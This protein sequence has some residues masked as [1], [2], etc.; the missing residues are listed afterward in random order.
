MS[1][2]YIPVAQQ[3]VDQ[4]ETHSVMDVLKSGKFAA[5]PKCTEFERK[6][7]AFVGRKALLCNSGSSA[8]LLAISTLSAKTMPEMGYDRLKKG[9]EVITP[10]CTFPTTVNPLFQNGFVPVFVDVDIRTLNVSLEQIQ[11]G[12]STKTKAIVVP[13]TLGNVCEIDKISEWCKKENLYLIEDACDAMGA[14]MNGQK[15]GT[16]GDMATSSFFPAHHVSCGEGGA[17]FVSTN[18]LA[19]VVESLRDWG[20]A[21][22]C[23]PGCDNTCKKRFDYQLGSLPSGYDHKYSYSN[24][25]YNLK[26]SDLQAAI[27]CAQMGKLEGFIQKRRDNWSSLYCGINQSSILSEHLIAIEPTPGSTPSWFGFAMHLDPKL[28][29]RDLMKH[30]EAHQVGTRMVFGGNITRQ[31]GYEDENFKVIR[32]L[33]NCDR[34][35]NHTFWIAVH[36]GLTEDNIDFMLQTL[37]DGIN[38]QL[39]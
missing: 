12:F 4:A 31:P 18:R 8:N 6:L 28:S 29:R 30:M 32:E 2:P 13:H 39:K 22:W 38:A 15:V 11:S 3:I 16:F 36:P 20:R 34:I 17:V 19:R 35:M 33:Q 10:A 23:N 7:E 14:E 9:D 27:G 5:G 1:N 25:G 21:C 24:L 37:E 26:L